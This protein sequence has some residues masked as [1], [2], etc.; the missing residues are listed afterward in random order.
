M[1]PHICGNLGQQGQQELSGSTLCLRLFLKK[2]TTTNLTIEIDPK[3]STIMSTALKTKKQSDNDD[4]RESPHTN[5]DQSTLVFNQEHQ[6]AKQ[7]W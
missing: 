7:R 5:L 2:K 3:N 4:K 1:F 6:R